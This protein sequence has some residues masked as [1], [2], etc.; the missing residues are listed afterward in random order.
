MSDKIQGEGDY[1]SA[2]RYNKH[3]AESAKKT[4]GKI[5]TRE[6]PDNLQE[7]ERAEQSGKRRAKEL[8]H[9]QKD[10]SLM[11]QPVDRNSTE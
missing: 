7:L 11:R 9:D 6:S 4:I 8:Q 5:P 1:E 3:T 2:R 10:A